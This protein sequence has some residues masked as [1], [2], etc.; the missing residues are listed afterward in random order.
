MKRAIGVLGATAIGLAVIGCGSSED[1]SIQSS[2]T[3]E[4]RAV[5]QT[6]LE[7][8]DYAPSALALGT[9]LQ[10]RGFECNELEGVS[11]IGALDV[12]SEARCWPGRLFISLSTYATEAD[13]RSAL[14][15]RQ[16]AQQLSKG[17][18]RS[19]LAYA[20]NW[21]IE[22]PGGGPGEEGSESCAAARDALGGTFDE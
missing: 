11:G 6:E 13:M 16:G 12:V 22:C 3:S 9:E 8:Y 10:R 20:G 1:G 2:A 14:K 7:V 15:I 21:I 5:T 17:I 19:S 18:G 4:T